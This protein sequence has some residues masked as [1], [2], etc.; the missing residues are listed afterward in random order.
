MSS[1]LFARRC[2]VVAAFAAFLMLVPTASASAASAPA[3]WGAPEAYGGDSPTVTAFFSTSC[4]SVGNC[5]AVGVTNEAGT[6]PKT[7]VERPVLATESAGTWGPIS[8]VA[9]PPG[10][11]SLEG[12]VDLLESVSCVSASSCTAVGEYA[13]AAGGTEAMVVPIT[14]AGGRATAGTASAVALP[15]GADGPS[16]QSAVLTG[17]SC[18]TSDC[19]AVGYYLTEA[20]VTEP[21]IATRSGGGEWIASATTPPPAATSGVLNAISCPKSGACEAV[22]TFRDASKDSYPWAVEIAGGKAGT[23]QVVTFPSNFKAT[24]TSGSIFLGVESVGLT[25]ISCPQA[26]VCTAAGDYPTGSGALLG[27]AALAGMTIP[28]TDGVPGTSTELQDAEAGLETLIDGIWCS[29]AGDCAVAGTNVGPLEIFGTHP[30]A[31]TETGGSWSSL[32]GFPAPKS[33]LITLVTSMT[34]ATV[35]RCIASGISI[36]INPAVTPATEG[37]ETFFANSAPL[38][39][40]ATTSLPPATAGVPYNAALQ[41]AGGTGSASWSVGPGSLPPGL[42]LNPATGV[43]SGTPTASGQDGFIATASDP[44]PP[45]QTASVGLSIAVNP[46]P[47]VAPAHAP[48]PAPTVQAAYLHTSGAKVTFVIGCTGAPCTGTV[49]LTGVIGTATHGRRGAQHGRHGAHASRA[50]SHRHSHGA[51]DGKRTTTLAHG[52]YSVAAGHTEVLTLTLTRAARRL[53]ARLHRIS[54]HLY[55]TPTGA[56]L[57]AIVEKVTFTSHAVSRKHG[58]RHRG[59]KGRR[60]HGRRGGHHRS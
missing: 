39:S 60:R 23:A 13:N 30:I 25:T 1:M 57:P 29:D 28:I 53:L 32:T 50:R 33:S 20:S 36:T 58:K 19:T 56:S 40:V 45:V 44:G 2:A 34:C 4:S 3:V 16:S 9:T 46:A 14:I 55:V 15:K 48:A 8:I 52:S 5:V 41:A 24:E 17:V 43:I 38:L 22:G 6:A 18:S 37:Y 7:T 21:M 47:F 54:G 10:P 31:A 26:G 27:E 35:D 12:R 51:K 42:S 49:K 59:P 11:S